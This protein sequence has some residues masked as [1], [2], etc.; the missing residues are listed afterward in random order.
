M[1]VGSQ[2]THATLSPAFTCTVAGT[3]RNERMKTSVEP[4]TFDGVVQ[5]AESIGVLDVERSETQALMPVTTSARTMTAT[6]DARRRV[7]DRW[8]I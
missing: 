1:S 7:K 3:N 6:A 4:A 2:F 5:L 8:L